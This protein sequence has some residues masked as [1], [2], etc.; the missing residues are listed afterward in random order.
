MLRLLGLRLNPALRAV[1]GAALLAFGYAHDHAPVLML[2]G[3]ALI[4]WGGIGAVSSLTRRSARQ[5]SHR[6]R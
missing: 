1:I 5:T 2:V 4:A 6:P 3:G